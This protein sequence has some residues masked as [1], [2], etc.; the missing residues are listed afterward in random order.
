LREKLSRLA[1][2][3]IACMRHVCHRASSRVA[4]AGG[5]RPVRR[6]CA[7]QSSLRRLRTLDRMERREAQPVSQ[8]GARLRTAR[9]AARSQGWPKG[10]SQ[11]PGASRRSIPLFIGGTPQ[12]P[13]GKEKGKRPPRGRAK[14]T[15]DDAC[16]A[17]PPKPAGRRRGPI[18]EHGRWRTPGQPYVSQLQQ[19]YGKYTQAPGNAV[20]AAI[21]PYPAP[22][23]E[24]AKRKPRA[25][26][27]LRLYGRARNL[28]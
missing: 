4:R 25:F 11:A 5:A 3:P 17:R 13:G 2:L 26:A 10:A 16:P 9:K 23:S 27:A 19:F 20:N 15:G 14:N 6:Q 12:T 1:C 21:W 8:T 24:P 7:P 28:G 18:K 22:T